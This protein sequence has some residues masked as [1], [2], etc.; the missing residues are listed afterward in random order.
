MSTL[1]NEVITG[2]SYSN[3]TLSLTKSGGGSVDINFPESESIIRLA[4]NSVPLNINV[5]GS[6]PARED[7]EVFYANTSSRSNEYLSSNFPICIESCLFTSKTSGHMFTDLYEAS[8][9]STVFSIP[10]M[11]D[12][13]DGSYSFGYAISVNDTAP[14]YGWYNVSLTKSGSNFKAGP[15]GTEMY[16][17]ARNRTSGVSLIFST[18][19]RNNV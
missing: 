5:F 17:G 9:N 3:N 12:M 15:F 11:S 13:P 10:E 4:T 14:T 7:Y 19:R 1:Q 6:E 2:G 8:R 16:I 18:V